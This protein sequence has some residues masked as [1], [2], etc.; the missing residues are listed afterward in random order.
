MKLQPFFVRRALAAVAALTLAF[1]LAVGGLSAA[2]PALVKPGLPKTAPATADS[3]VVE[4]IAA[5]TDAAPAYE[6]EA[7]SAVVEPSAPSESNPQ[8]AA[9]PQNELAAFA[10]AVADGGAGLRGVYVPGVLALR[11]VQPPAGAY[12]VDLRPG[13]ATQFS[14]ASAYGVTGLLADNIASGVQFYSLAYG[15][16]VTL[17][18]G[19]G[20]QRRYVVGGVARYQAL[21]PTDPYSNFVDLGTGAQISSS[22]LFTQMYTGGDKVTFQ[23]CL[24]KDGVMAWGRLFVT[25]YPAP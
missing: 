5:T 1:T 13:V 22:T 23:T 18:F 17:I 21:N 8:L 2:G 4:T 12:S 20:T 16:E 10:A 25:A 24:A 11:V 9:Q 3:E 15:Q 14:A 7:I 6:A 19:D